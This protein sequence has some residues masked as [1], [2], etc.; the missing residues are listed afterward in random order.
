[1]TIADLGRRAVACKHWRWMPGML[2]E[3]LGFRVVWFDDHMIGESDQVSYFWE[4]VPHIYPDLSD[5]ATL[6]CLL[7]LVRE[8][9][10]D[11]VTPTP[12]VSASDSKRRWWHIGLGEHVIGGVSRGVSLEAESESEL[13]VAALEAAP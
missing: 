3:P 7:A 9:W 11:D 1:M 2:V 5:H 4:R 10:K 6:G 8:V 13:L 12:I